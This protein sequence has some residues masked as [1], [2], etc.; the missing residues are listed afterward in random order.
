MP[1]KEEFGTHISHEKG[2]HHT[3]K[4]Q[5]GSTEVVRRQKTDGPRGKSWPEPVFAVSTGKARYHRVNNLGLA[6]FE[7]FQGTVGHRD[8]PWLWDGL[9]QGKSWHGCKN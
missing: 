5:R 4:G 1:G 6:K 8:G 9:E 3:T 7:S 2:T